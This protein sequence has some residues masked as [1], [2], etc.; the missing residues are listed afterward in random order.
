MK[1]EYQCPHCNRMQRLREGQTTCRQCARPLPVDVQL[2]PAVAGVEQDPVTNVLD[3]YTTFGER[4]AT[5]QDDLA[6]KGEQVHGQLAAA[7]TNSALTD[8]SPERISDFL[9][10]PFIVERVAPGDYLIHVPSFMNM[11]VGWPVKVGGSFTTYRLNVYSMFGSDGLPEWIKHHITL[12]DP[13][14]ITIEEEEGD[15]WVVVG[16]RTTQ[17]VM[18]MFPNMVDAPNTEGKYRIKGGDEGVYLV[19]MLLV[20]E[21]RLLQK[22]V[23]VPDGALHP[24][25]TAPFALRPHQQADWD[26]FRQYGR[27]GVFKPP[28]AGKSFLGA[29]ACKLVVGPNIVFAPSLMLVKQWRQWI[30]QWDIKD[31][32]VMTYQGAV[33]DET[34]K[35]RQFNLV[36]FDECHRTPSPT[37]RYLACLH[38]Q[39]SIGLSA[40]PFREDGQEAQIYALT[41][42]PVFCDWSHHFDKNTDVVLPRVRLRVCEDSQ[43]RI[44]EAARLVNNHVVGRTLLFV[45]H[46]KVGRYLADTLG[47]PFWHHKNQPA[48]GDLFNPTEG[49]WSRVAEPITTAIVT[50]IADE[51]LAIHDLRRVV[52]VESIGDSR[53]QTIQRF[54]RLLA[55]SKESEYIILLTKDERVKYSKK[56]GEMFSREG[57]VIHEEI[58][59]GEV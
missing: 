51:G 39:Y 57:F 52:E 56:L 41:G 59:E 10:E 35:D 22:V 44:I 26:E 42:K 25:S 14:D 18:E 48:G 40:S 53:R 12:P 54:G 9:K 29:Y 43:A 31:T 46:L 32:E 11:R 15:S 58:V 17:Q 16:D 20:Q 33:R 27:I 36:V 45:E 24:E 2:P 8:I 4:M 49:H 1:T 6:T 30:A 21:G 3:A 19:R 34:L 13:P 28:R 47:V 38:Y 23:P 55:N 5:L 7:L 37:F 50:R